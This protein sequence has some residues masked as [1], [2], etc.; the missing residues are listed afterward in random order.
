MQA[1]KVTQKYQATIPLKI[2]ELLHIEKGDQVI[3]ELDGDKVVIRKAEPLD[4]EHLKALEKTLSEW[5][6]KADDEAYRDL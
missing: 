5:S 3:F 1:S 6:S 4:L 2:R